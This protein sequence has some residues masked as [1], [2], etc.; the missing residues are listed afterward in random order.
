MSLYTRTWSDDA[1]VNA[2]ASEGLEYV[3][4]EIRGGVILGCV[5][6]HNLAYPMFV[7]VVDL[8]FT[9]FEAVPTWATLSDVTL[10]ASK[11]RSRLVRSA[12]HFVLGSI[13]SRVV[14]EK[15]MSPV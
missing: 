10:V 5:V 11:R 4:G 9:I 7:V 14:D 15:G 12:D 6:V 3:G 1:R 2:Y 13:A 8:P